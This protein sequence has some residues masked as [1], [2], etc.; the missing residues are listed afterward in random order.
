MV[1]LLDGTT[2]KECV[3]AV[4]L[5][6]QQSLEEI[7]LRGVVKMVYVVFIYRVVNVS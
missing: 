5:T 1:L 6:R 3:R 4:Y 7:I 2:C